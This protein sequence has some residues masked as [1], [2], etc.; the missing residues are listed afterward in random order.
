V[1]AILS[2]PAGPPSPSAI[3]A[4]LVLGVVCSAVAFLLFFALSAEVGPA[5]ASVI[6]YVHP[7]VAV[8]LGV[9]LLGERVAPATLSGLLLILAGSWLSTR[10]RP[11]GWPP[12]CRR[13][14]TG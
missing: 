6:T 1:P 10:A 11:V 2:A 12:G 14:P 7:A 3:G 9:R 8:L 4:V 13:L 5:R